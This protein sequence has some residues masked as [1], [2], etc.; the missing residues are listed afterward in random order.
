MTMRRRSTVWLLETGITALGR[1]VTR[2]NTF[3]V[4]VPEMNFDDEAIDQGDYIPRFRV[5][6]P[7]RQQL[8]QFRFDSNE[9]FPALLSLKNTEIEQPITYW[10]VYES[11]RQQE[12]KYRAHKLTISLCKLLRVTETTPRDSRTPLVYTYHFQAEAWNK[13]MGDSDDSLFIYENV[14]LDDHII[15]RYPLTFDAEGNITGRGEVI[16]YLDNSKYPAVFN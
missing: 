10:N 3:N 1:G 11:D 13:A 9:H 15:E 14:N 6:P 8:I 2:N 7:N 5:L 16:S 4:V 12:E